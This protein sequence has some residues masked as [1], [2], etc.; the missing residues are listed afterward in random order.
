[1]LD[2]FKRTQQVISVFPS[3]DGKFVPHTSYSR[4]DGIVMDFVSKFNL[5]DYFR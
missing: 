4:L 5:L 2:V 3:P 1:M